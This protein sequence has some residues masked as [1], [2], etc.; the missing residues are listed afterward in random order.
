[1]NYRLAFVVAVLVGTFGW[2]GY[3]LW[4]RAITERSLSSQNAGS[5]CRFEYGADGCIQRGI[6]PLRSLLLEKHDCDYWAV[7]CL[8]D[9]D[10]PEARDIMI[11]V[12]KTKAD[13]QTCDGVIPVRSHAVRYLG[14]SGD[15]S[16]VEPLRA[17]M[18]SEP[19]ETL[20]AGATGCDANAE[21]LELIQAAISKLE[22]R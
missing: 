6:H 12:L 22:G 17:L 10:T 19:M 8:A 16:A 7:Q 11:E 20:S 15:I 1:M 21:D 4:P 5:H 14:D 18:A 13:V 3:V 2:M 9:F